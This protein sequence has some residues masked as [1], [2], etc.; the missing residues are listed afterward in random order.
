MLQ[1]R[2]YISAAYQP[3][4]IPSFEE[5]YFL[6]KKGN[7]TRSIEPNE[8]NNIPPP[9]KKE[10]RIGIILPTY[11]SR[12]NNRD[13]EYAVS[14]LSEQLKELH[15]HSS[16]IEL[17]V[18]LGMQWQGLEEQEAFLRVNKGLNILSENV[19]FAIIG[20]TVPILNK[21]LTLNIFFKFV[22]PLEIAGMLWIDDD[23]TMKPHCLNN[24][25]M[26]FINNNSEGAYGAKKIPVKKN[27]N[28]SKFLSFVKKF[29]KTK[30]RQYPHGCCMVVSKK[31]IS[32]GIPERFIGIGEDGYFCFLLLDP[33]HY[34]PLHNLKI[35]ED[36]EC[37]YYVG[38]PFRE[39]YPRLRRTILHTLILMADFPKKTSRYYFREIWFYGL[40]PFGAFEKHKHFFLAFLKYIFKFF[41][42]IWVAVV[43]VKLVFRG[44]FKHPLTGIKWAA[45]CKYMAPSTINENHA[46]S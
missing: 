10:T 2:K 25:I 38:G 40:W 16:H 17:I 31:Y 6:K 35:A 42:F 33:L 22:R 20:S 3:L 1:F 28:G 15:F 8:I 37:Y 44:L 27:F 11:V 26:R 41:Y 24:L 32:D 5:K 30:S 36:A 7:I 29:I 21:N 13:F 12:C 23:I 34:A 39:L 18:F 9:S 14:H 45:Y 46:E 4:P 19:P 43:W